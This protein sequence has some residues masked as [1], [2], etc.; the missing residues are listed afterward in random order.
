MGSFAAV[1]AAVLRPGNNMQL[2]GVAT[3]ASTAPA[4]AVVGRTDCV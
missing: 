4:A 1:L 2:G 3:S